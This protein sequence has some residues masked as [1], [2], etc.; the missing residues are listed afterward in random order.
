MSDGNAWS[1]LRRDAAGVASL[2]TLVLMALLC[3]GS[4]VW[5]PHPYDAVFPDYI[6]VP[7]SISAHPDAAELADGLADLSERARLRVTRDSTAGTLAFSGDAPIDPRVL[8][9]LERSDMFAQ[10]GAPVDLGR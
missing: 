3:F 9:Y 2:A 6:A 10:A 8:R 1:R 5:A 4:I 7:A